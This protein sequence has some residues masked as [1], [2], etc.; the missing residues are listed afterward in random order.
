MISGVVVHGDERGR[1]LGFPTANIPLTDGQ[2]IEFGV[3]A[4]RVGDHLAAVNIGIR[5]TFGLEQKPLLEAYLLDFEGD[6]YGQRIEVELVERL[7]PE[8]EFSSVA[9]LVAQMEQDVVDVRQRMD[10]R[11]PTP[12]TTS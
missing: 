5:P 12:V 2:P 3:Y 10:A 1:E 11:A 7:R 9:E 8:V 6:L 4:A